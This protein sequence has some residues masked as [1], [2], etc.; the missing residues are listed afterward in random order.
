MYEIVDDN[1]T[2]H[3][4]SDKSEMVEAFDSMT[5]CLRDFARNYS[6]AIGLARE[7]KEQYDSDWEGDLKLI[8]VINV[9]R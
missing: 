2:I 3:S 6:Y 5:M 1:G 8:K 4:S 7:T 9:S